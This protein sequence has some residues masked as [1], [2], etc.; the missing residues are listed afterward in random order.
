MYYNAERASGPMGYGFDTETLRLV[1][2]WD[3]VQPAATNRSG[4]LGKSHKCRD[5]HDVQSLNS[6]RFDFSSLRV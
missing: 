2:L 1:N 6:V 3:T 4:R 5:N